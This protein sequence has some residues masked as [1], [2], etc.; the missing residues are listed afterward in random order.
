MRQLADS[1]LGLAHGE[2]A[3]ITIRRVDLDFSELASSV[4]KSFGIQADQKQVR[5]EAL[6]GG[7]GAAGAGRSGQTFV[8]GVQPGG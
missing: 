5:L 3:A 2:P 1:L 4:V 8:G 7:A 6:I